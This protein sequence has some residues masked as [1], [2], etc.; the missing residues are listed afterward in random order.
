M[1]KLILMGLYESLALAVADMTRVPPNPTTRIEGHR[2]AK[3]TPN[4][5]KAFSLEIFEDYLQ[6]FCRLTTSLV[7]LRV[8]PYQPNLVARQIGLSELLPKCVIPR[9]ETLFCM[10][11]TATE[12]WLKGSRL[13]Y[14]KKEVFFHAFDYILSYHCTQEFEE[15]WAQH[16]SLVPDHTMMAQCLVDAFSFLRERGVFVTR[17]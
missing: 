12:R 15:W 10:L 11:D 16:W 9:V 6:M 1:S 14:I 7:G 4:D 5:G 3:L 17:P 8:A 2:L 13:V